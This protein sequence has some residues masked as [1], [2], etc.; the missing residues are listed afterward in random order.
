MVSLNW[1]TTLLQMLL[2]TISVTFNWVPDATKEF[3]MCMSRC[4]PLQNNNPWDICYPFLVTDQQCQSD[5]IHSHITVKS[6]YNTVIFIPNPHNRHQMSLQEQDMEHPLCMQILVFSLYLAS[7]SFV[8]WNVILYWTMYDWT[9]EYDFNAWNTYWFSLSLNDSSDLKSIL[10]IITLQ[11]KPVL[12]PWLLTDDRCMKI[13][14]H[15]DNQH[16]IQGSFQYPLIHLIL[17]VMS[18]QDCV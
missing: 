12:Y 1:F 8:L 2:L 5:R 7:L 3:V 17:T 14:Q 11:W 13:C 6:C 16:Q 15:H 18:L 9:Q 4:C 10:D